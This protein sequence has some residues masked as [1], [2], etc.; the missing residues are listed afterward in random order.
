VTNFF[1]F[2]FVYFDRVAGIFGLL[3]IDFAGGSGIQWA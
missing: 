3:G 1:D 2:L